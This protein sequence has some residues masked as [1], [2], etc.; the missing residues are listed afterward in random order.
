MGWH[1]HEELTKALNELD[2]AAAESLKGCKSLEAWSQEGKRVLKGSKCKGHVGGVAVFSE[3]QCF[4]PK[5]GSPQRPAHR[6]KP[7][8]K[9]P[10]L[11]VHQWVER[12]D[13]RDADNYNAEPD[14]FPYGDMGAD[15][16]GD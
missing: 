2:A 6:P 7:V 9:P 13:P 4:T 1:D 16:W 10:T 14:N 15:Y 3:A 12:V 8:K 5:K 11:R